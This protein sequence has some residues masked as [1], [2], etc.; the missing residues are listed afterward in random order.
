MK[1][2]IYLSFIAISLTSCDTFWEAMALGLSNYNSTGGYN[3]YYTP[4]STSSNYTGLLP[5]TPTQSSYTTSY[6]SSSSSS[7]NSYSSSSSSSSSSSK[8]V[9][10]TCRRC[11]GDGKCN[12]CNGS[13]KNVERIGYKNP[14][15]CSTCHGSGK[16]SSC[17]GSGHYN[18]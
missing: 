2:F 3:T 6:S 11:N 17:G 9:Y 4:Y 16:C 18:Y 13:G 8:K 14:T 1:K 7:S 5:Y 15:T 10:K 12:P